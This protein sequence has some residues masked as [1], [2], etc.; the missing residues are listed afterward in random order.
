MRVLIGCVI[1]VV[2]W[3]ND[4]FAQTRAATAR[5]IESATL[6]SDPR[7]DSAL[8]AAVPPGLVIEVFARSGDW[9]QAR[10]MGAVVRVGWIHSSLIEL[11][12]ADASAALASTDGAA[13][14]PSPQGSEHVP[15]PPQSDF[16]SG[17]IELLIDGGVAGWNEA[18]E[19]TGIFQIDSV[20]GFVAS[21]HL[22][23]VVSTSM[24]KAGGVDAFGTFGGG[25]LVNFPGDGPVVPFVGAVIGRGFGAS[26]LFRGLVDDPTFVNAS[27][28]VRVLTGG[29]GGALIVRPFYERYFNSSDVFPVSDVNRFGISLGASI[30]F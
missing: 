4:G 30:L 9:Y 15:P 20:V 24:L 21:R 25:L 12:P 16:S 28:G 11:L 10:T 19:T 1:A 23:V 14:P 5:T 18:G 13:P 2:I 8:V 7:G 27:G 22:E 3:A 6:L 17:H 29:G 26:S